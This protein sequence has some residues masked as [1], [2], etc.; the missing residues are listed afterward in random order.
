M[1]EL[2]KAAKSGD[3]DAFGKLYETVYVDMYKYALYM[4]RNPEDAEDAVAD[5]VTDAYLEIKNLR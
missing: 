1:T 4:L 3:R 2:I 5:A